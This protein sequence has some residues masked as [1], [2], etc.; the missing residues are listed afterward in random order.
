LLTCKQFLQELDQYL[1]KTLE[2]AQYA[3]LQKHIN[4]C[5]NCFVV[6]DTTEKTLKVF[7]GME[8]KPV[9]ADIHSRLMA[10]IQEKMQHKCGGKAEGPVDYSKPEIKA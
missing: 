8:C 7:K 5:P 10:A 3:E 9:P 6:C 1:E 4:E 2:P